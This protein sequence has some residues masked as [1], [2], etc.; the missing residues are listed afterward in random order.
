MLKLSGI[1]PVAF[2]YKTRNVLSYL[3]R[4][5][6]ESFNDMKAGEELSGAAGAE[7]ILDAAKK[8]EEACRRVQS[9]GIG[10]G[11]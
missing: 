6:Q 11:I 2:D 5:A 8:F 10:A 4:I 1:R 9:L 7:A 3:A